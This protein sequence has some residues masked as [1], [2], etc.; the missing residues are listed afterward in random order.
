MAQNFRVSVE[1]AQAKAKMTHLRKRFTQKGVDSVVKKVAWVTHRRL[2]QRTPKK[3]T[4]NTRK[5]WRTYRLGPANYSVTN[6]SK[7]MVF[8]EN[9]TRAHGPKRAKRLFIPLTRKAA[10]AGPRKVMESMKSGSAR[11]GG[12]TPYKIG[13]DFVLAK[14][15]KGIKARRIVG[16]Q[17][18]LSRITLKAEMRLHIRRILSAYE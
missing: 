11:E 12:K 9:G 5:S 10:L 4:G 1:G 14:R 2:V 15:V 16:S 3:W 6:L 8:L 7:V 17:R 18:P 13:K